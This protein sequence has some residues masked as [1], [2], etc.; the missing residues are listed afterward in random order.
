MLLS[1]RRNAITTT[2]GTIFIPITCYNRATYIILKNALFCLIA[3]LNML[4]IGR[5][6]KEHNIVIDGDNNRLKIRKVEKEVA[7][8]TWYNNIA[9]LT[10]LDVPTPRLKNE[11][12]YLA[13]PFMH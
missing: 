4:S 10:K 5:L 1:N 12:S 2:I 6:L 7:Y 3:P 9:I 11:M 8:I 13:I